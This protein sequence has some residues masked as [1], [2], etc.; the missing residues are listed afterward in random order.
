MNRRE[1]MLAGTAFA[2]GSTD[3]YA[4]AEHYSGAG[5]AGT[6][7][8]RWIAAH[9]HAEQLL[10]TVDLSDPGVGDP[11]GKIPHNR[12]PL[13]R[14]RTVGCRRYGEDD[15]CRGRGADCHFHRRV[16]C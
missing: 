1:L 4:Q 6:G 5:K 2:I 14:A 7:G 12:C 9:P 15:G 11:Q 3:T 13:P 10:P 16:D 8:N